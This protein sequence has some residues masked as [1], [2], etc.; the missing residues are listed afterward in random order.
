MT[1][2]REPLFARNYRDARHRLLAVAATRPASVAAHQHPGPSLDEAPLYT[3][4]IRV[5][6][7]DATRV[8]LIVSGTHG[9]EGF[10]GSTIQVD[11]LQALPALGLQADAAVV[12]VHALNPYGFAWYRRVDQDNVDVNRNFVEH[13]VAHPDN[14]EYDALHGVLCPT[15][16]NETTRRQGEIELAEFQAQHGRA[17][18]EGMLARGQY[19]HADGLFFGGRAP[20]WSNALLRSVLAS[21]AAT[22]KRV[23]LLD[24][25]TGLGP[26]GAC[27]LICGVDQTAPRAADVR[28]WLGDGA[29]FIGPASGFDRLPGA[30]DSTVEQSLPGIEVTPVTVEFGTLPALDVLQALRADNWLHGQSPHPELECPIKQD[31]R[32]SFCP[33]DADWGELVV[34][35]GRQVVARALRGLR[36]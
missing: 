5:G 25:H 31:M 19:R 23:T 24:I 33:D 29:Q 15:R 12:L 7:P 8:L 3:D 21:I 18:L 14:P 28:S 32:R 26:Y 30:I 13:T 10:A 6:A 9:V 27:Q 34:L 22:A 36:A 17:A 4:V 1:Q 11:F 20:S 35:R 16:W 2:P